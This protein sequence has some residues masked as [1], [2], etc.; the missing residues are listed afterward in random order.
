MRRESG[1]AV[2]ID[3]GLSRHDQLPDLLA[4]EFRLPVGT[5]PYLSPEQ[6]MGDRSDPHSDTFALGVMLYL[7]ATGTHPFGERESAR[8]LRKR[9]Y[10]EPARRPPR[11]RHSFV[12]RS[13]AQRCEMWGVDHDCPDPFRQ[14]HARPDRRHLRCGKRA[15][16]F[17]IWVLHHSAHNSKGAAFR[18]IVLASRPLPRQCR[19]RSCKRAKRDSCSII[20]NG[21]A[22]HH[23]GRWLEAFDR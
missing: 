6:V 23:R 12:E 18:P 3:F 5:A 7:F 20:R 1:E 15:R 2:L 16:H 21:V 22:I 10:R 8:A 14:Q 11:L 17:S 13:N 9:L 4:E 19:S